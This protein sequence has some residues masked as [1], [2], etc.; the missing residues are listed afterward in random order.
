M[1][2]FLFSSA[3]SLE[4]QKNVM[5]LYVHYSIFFGGQQE[6]EKSLCMFA[7]VSRSTMGFSLAIVGLE[8]SFLVVS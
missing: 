6:D 2:A 8:R 1:N 3:L 5:R 7:I 4:A